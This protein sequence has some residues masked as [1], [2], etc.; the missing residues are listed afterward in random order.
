MND[1]QPH[2]FF[3]LVLPITY[4]NT[5][6]CKHSTGSVSLKRSFLWKNLLKDTYFNSLHFLFTHQTMQSIAGD[7]GSKDTLELITFVMSQKSS[8]HWMDAPPTLLGLNPSLGKNTM[9]H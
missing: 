6:R 4:R 5:Q 1:L 3:C 9:L 2:I 8:K 7:P